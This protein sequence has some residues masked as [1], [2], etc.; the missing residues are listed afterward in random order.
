[1]TTVLIWVNIVVFLLTFF[2]GKE[3]FEAILDQWGYVPADHRLVTL[4]TY[5][6]LHGGILHVLGNMLFLWIFGA[7][8]EDRLGRLGFLAFYLA[9]GVAAILFFVHVS[10][11][12]LATDP[13]AGASGAIYAVMGAFF[14]LFPL[15]EIRITFVIMVM[16]YY[17]R[18]RT[19]WTAAFF[20]APLYVLLNLLFNAIDIE[21]QVAFMAHVGGFLFAIPCGLLF[22]ALFPVPRPAPVAEIK[23]EE[24]QP[25]PPQNERERLIQDLKDALYSH[26]RP[27]AMRLYQQGKKQFGSL[28]LPAVDSL[29][30]AEA[31]VWEEQFRSAV[32]VYKQVAKSKAADPTLR[33]RAALEVGRLYVGPLGDIPRGVRVF[34]RALERFPTAGPTEDIRRELGE[35][36]RKG[37]PLDWR[38]SGVGQ[39]SEPP[40]TPDEN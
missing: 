4:F 30:L 11:L 25:K 21:G 17:W 39:A 32:E 9:S 27:K 10:G 13:C 14:V 35:L 24:E 20:I 23:L 1:M 26:L 31:M 28:P 36:E 5:Q 3:N 7:N 37:Y 16:V 6:F 8:V 33:A 19:F 38:S 2:S 18:V 29:A 12:E 22:R 15:A 34:R 40:A